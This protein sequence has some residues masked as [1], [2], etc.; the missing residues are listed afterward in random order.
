MCSAQRIKED[1]LLAGNY[2]GNNF[3]NACKY[4]VGSAED[5]CATCQ[6]N[7]YVVLSVSIL[8]YQSIYADFSHVHFVLFFYAEIALDLC[9]REPI[10]VDL[11][12]QPTQVYV[13][14]FETLLS[15]GL[16][17]ALKWDP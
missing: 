16:L 1:K 6:N 14:K 7:K 2:V 9:M 11:E 5:C 15:L 4:Q 17:R 8:S 3:Y 10:A 13:S 12:V